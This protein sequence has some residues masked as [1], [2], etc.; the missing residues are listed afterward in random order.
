MRTV[1]FYLPQFHTIPENDEWWGE[2]FTEWV[3][4]EAAEPVYAEHVHPRQHGVLGRYDL[5]DRMIH[6]QQSLLARGHGV[7]AFCMYFYWFNGHRL[8]EAPTNA[9]REDPSLLPYCLSW[10]NESWTRRWDGKSRSVLMSQ[11]YEPGFAAGLFADLLPHFRAPHYLRHAGLPILL[12]HRADHIPDAPGFARELRA[13]AIEAG[14]PGLHLVA[15]E[16]TPGLRP[17]SVGFDAVAEFP[18]VGANTLRT[19]HL[20]PLAGVARGFRGRLMSYEKLAR[21]FMTRTRP[22]FTR[23]RGVAPAWDN[24]AR[25]RNAATVYV[26]ASPARYAHW[27]ASAIAGEDRDRGE[28]G[29]VFVNAWNEW[30]EGAYL[31]PDGHLGDEYL[32][33]TAAPSSFVATHAVPDPRR[34]S[35]W[36]LAQLHS[37]ALTAAGS[38]IAAVRR[39]RNSVRIDGARDR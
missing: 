33:A 38:A 34:G 16:T 25:R 18:P 23:Y 14:L 3:N 2:G 29:I 5:S 31:E 32:R 11:D 9:W 30:A 22:E 4:V 37:I 35:F 6:R 13:L 10:A 19:A 1:A 21:R 26:G 36:S 12:V 24:T 39:V 27:L 17:A 7:D 15:A 8:L 20:S 28:A